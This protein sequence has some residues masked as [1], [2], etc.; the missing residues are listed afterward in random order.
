M[1]TG[2][3]ALE[4][5]AKMN[6]I[7]L[8]IRTVVRDYGLS[9]AELTPAELLRVFM[10]HGFKAK[11]KKLPLAQLPQSGYPMPALVLKKD[12]TYAVLLKL[13][14]I[15]NKALVFDPVKKSTHNVPFAQLEADCTGE[16]IIVKHKL[17]QSQIKF[18]FA[19]FYGEII[20]YRLVM[21]EVLLGSFVVQLFGLVTPLFTQVIMDKVIAN[22]A[23][24]TLMVLA[25]GF[26]AIALFEFVLNLTRNY[27]FIHTANKIDAKLGSR[28]F[29]HLFSLPYV[30]FESRKVGNIV[31]RVRELDSI[32]EFMTNRSVS[33]IIDLIFSLVFLGMMLIY[34]PKLAMIVV[35]FISLIALLYLF[36]T[37]PLRS[38]LE[39]KFQMG[40]QAN[41]YLVESVTGI[42]TVKS[43]AIEGMMQKKWEDYLG[44]YLQSS[45]NLSTMA[46]GA[47]AVSQL[48]QKGITV[49][50]LYLGVG[51]VLDNQL[52][53]GQLIAFQMFA[54]QLT[55]P[56]LRLVNLWND[57]QQALLGVE[58]LGD[59]LNTP[60]EIQSAQAIT[61]AEVKGAVRFENIG[62][63]YGVDTPKVLEGLT[64]SLPPGVSLGIVGRSGSGKSTVTKLIQRLYIPQEGAI[65]IDDV[66]TRHMNPVWLRQQIGIVLQENYLFSGT[67]RENI[68]MP[69]PD[70]SI[71]E[72]IA[73]SKLA[74]AHEFISQLPEGY[75]TVVGER[76]S[77][78]SGGQR[79]RI[80][81]A[82]A[83]I[84]DPRILIFDEATSALDYESEKI[85]QDNLKQI[86]KGRTV[87]IIAH[88][89]ATV[90]D[91][92]M[93]FVLDK[94]KL[95]EAGTYQ[96]LLDKQGYFYKLSQQQGAVHVEP[97]A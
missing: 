79:Q 97:V 70:A 14:P 17:I 2:L 56:V 16:L 26:V 11:L 30:Y 52:T 83:L 86:R 96:E 46:T 63:R 21:A 66:D 5:I 57:F 22:H 78:L 8:D 84:T 74:G 41:S 32:R 60:V 29:K 4:L 37:P 88:R 48:L 15:D 9:E 87:V 25:V 3:I 27:I 50:V 20:K 75:D 49:T 93:I 59:I 10:A 42:Q 55:N 36:I 95:I 90:Q 18:G 34:S 58:R 80:A 19:W 76:G 6:Q 68:A 65:F 85:I 40:A 69:K 28:L 73:A 23:I 64:F 12:H 7:P 35:G 39:A 81:I 51:L 89:L 43:L 33:V 45:F 82:R 47:L 67:I 92:N 61:L 77:T 72:V 44:H 53:T 13:D 91:C 38:R 71:D 24:N 31:A 94:G 62:F 1:Q 54:S